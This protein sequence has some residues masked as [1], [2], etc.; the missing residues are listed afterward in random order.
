MILDR[1]PLRWTLPG[2]LLGFGLLTLGGLYYAELRSSYRRIEAFETAQIRLLGSI[3]ASDVEAALRRGDRASAR[4]SI[5]RARGDRDLM[6]A[7]LVGPNGIVILGSHRA[8]E[9][10][11][12]AETPL[13]P[14]EAPLRETLDSRAIHLDYAEDSARF[15]GT[16][17]VVLSDLPGNI[18]SGDSSVLVTL[19][20]LEMPFAFARADARRR[21]AAAAVLLALFCLLLW[22]FLSRVLLSRINALARAT[23]RIAGG[24]FEA[25]VAVRGHDELAQLSQSLHRMGSRLAQGDAELRRN[26]KFYR[27]II[28]NIQ[29]IVSIVDRD[30]RFVYVSASTTRISGYSPEWFIGKSAFVSVNEEDAANN[31]RVMEAVLSGKSDMG[32]FES[33]FDQADGTVAVYHTV[34]RRMQSEDGA[35]QLLMAS[36]NVS[37]L[38][39]VEM[40]LR[41]S[42][43]RFNSLFDS[44]RD[45]AWAISTDGP[46]FIYAN[47]A[48]EEIYGRSIQELQ[49]D[50]EF[51]IECA[52]PEDRE[53]ARQSIRD[54][55]EKGSADVEYRIVRP[56]GTVRW[57]HER[58]QLIYDA[59]GR[60]IRKGGLISDVTEA[61]MA[62]EEKERLEAQLRQTQKMEAVG[63]LAGGVAHDFNNL[64]TAINGYADLLLDAMGE[65]HELSDEVREI[66]T[67]GERAAALTR[68]L[69]LFSRHDIIEARSLDLN[70]LVRN[71]GRMLR[72]LI[73]EHIEFRSELDDEPI[74]IWA[75]PGQIEQ[76]IVNLMV[77]ARDAM[78]TGGTLTIRTGRVDFADEDSLDGERVTPGAYARLTVRDTGCGMSEEV[79]ARIFEPFFTTKEVGKGTGLGLATIYGIIR[80]SLGY[81]TVDSKEGE[82]STFDVYLPLAPPKEGSGEADSSA[83]TR[84]GGSETI[85]FVED[86]KVVREVGVRVL[87][88]QGYRVL[89]AADGEEALEQ[90]RAAGGRIDLV[91]SDMVMPR[92]TGRGL[93]ARLLELY[94]TIRILLVSGYADRRL[95]GDGD[96][97]ENLPFLQK[98][99]DPHTLAARVREILDSEPASHSS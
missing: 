68:Q 53:I 66:R 58:K 62:A 31:R 57:I 80:Q 89:A 39:R 25:D 44:L 98:P 45:G 63:T 36:R 94:P 13:A 15:L 65:E 92:M 71:L 60:P 14:A 59:E 79:R 52:H 19:H 73:G 56:D 87:A 37:Q 26:E 8:D 96:L 46:Q 54:V 4:R 81:I 27:S 43:S 30:L 12:V 88:M 51:W 70:E 38:K 85:L 95:G 74:L 35:P 86:E 84:R 76:V 40:A 77:N 50:P 91:V 69:L 93:V 97:P 90:A 72:R 1:W 9:G 29:D 32:E 7:A 11:H 83:G 10:K 78:E 64:L 17:P 23:D 24:E 48:V 28:E 3:T 18:Q 75:D 55:D 33:R 42:E 47:R 82:G 5:E 6:R 16:F 99:Y 2:I 41:E 20:S 61:R 22:V 21:L 67:A 49:A 34:C